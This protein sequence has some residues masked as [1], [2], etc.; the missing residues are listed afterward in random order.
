MASPSANPTPITPPRVAML[1]QRTGLI[2][3]EWYLFFLNLFQVSQATVDAEFSGADAG[4]Q[5]ASVQEALNQAAQTAGSRPASIVEQIQPFLDALALELQARVLS[6]LE[7]TRPA[8]DDL[9]QQIGT[10]PQ[11]NVVPPARFILPAGI[12]VGASPYTYQNTNSY[13]VDVIVRGGTVST[14]EFSRDNATYYN[15]GTIAGMFA[16]SPYDYLRVTYTV[17]PTMTAIPR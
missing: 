3:R 10:V 7:Q 4:S 14:V 2:T 8:L 6:S 5:I 13:P 15:V 9:A 11:P 17:A 12:T 1:D 16:L